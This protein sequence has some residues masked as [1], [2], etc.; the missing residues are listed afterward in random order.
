M[1]R[2][3]CCGK[4]IEETASEREKTQRWH[5]RCVRR[6]FGIDRLPE[7]E[8]SAAALDRI[9]AESTSRGFTVPGVQKKM[10]LHL[11]RDAGSPRL[12][13]VDYPA[14]Y[15]LK[16]QAEQHEAL[17]E[18][19]YLVMQMAEKTGIAVVPYAL[20][21]MSGG[22]AA[23][24]TKRID[25]V[26]P[27]KGRGKVKL[28]A[29]EDF[30][31]LENRLTENKYQSSYERCARIVSQYSVRPG[32]DL[33]ELFLRLVFSFAVGNSDM[34]L[35]NF[36]LIET[37]AE[38][39][40]YVLS[41]AYDM[42]PVNVIVPEDREQTALSLNGKKRNLRRGDFLRFA[43]TVGVPREAAVKMIGRV[44]SLQKTYLA[45]CRQSYL[46]DHM[47]TALAVLLA[48]RIETL[49]GQTD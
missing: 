44:V 46:P 48:E 26:L 7:L 47:K 15:I 29:M 36:S 2:C 41:R 31:Q 23:Y 33:S 9:A 19:E 3:L 24:I 16:P 27:A 18:A 39:G 14:G 32:L 20:I 8:L 6:F 10:S 40:E 12:T 43:E 37:A 21:R 30:C 25:R 13:L 4:P 42:L 17:P 34:H 35:K 22:P 45:M 5:D 38:S 28:L 11:S 1:I 49:R